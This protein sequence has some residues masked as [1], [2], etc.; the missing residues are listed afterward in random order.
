ML[1]WLIL[2]LDR[3]NRRVEERND[4]KA[5]A[6]QADLDRLRRNIERR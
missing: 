6:I 2:A 5:R 1:T 4:F 3:W